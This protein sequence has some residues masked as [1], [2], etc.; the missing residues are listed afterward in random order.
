VRD[1]LGKDAGEYTFV[2]AEHEAYIIYYC[3][4]IDIPFHARWCHGVV[5]WAWDDLTVEDRLFLYRVQNGYFYA[6]Y[7]FT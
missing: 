7:D 3:V 2:R 6:R 1:V 5:K 4:R